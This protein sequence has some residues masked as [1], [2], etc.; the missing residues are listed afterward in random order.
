MIRVVV[1]FA[2]VLL[3][4]LACVPAAGWAQEPHFASC[5]ASAIAGN[6]IVS[7]Q[8]AGL[9]NQMRPPTPLH[10]E[11]TVTAVCLDQATT[12]PTVLDAARVTEGVTFPPKNGSRR[13]ALVV[14]EGLVLACD[15]PAEVAVGI[16]VTDVT[17]AIA[18][19]PLLP[20]APEPE[21]PLEINPLPE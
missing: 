4:A 11:A 6:L 15:P 18:C 5:N 12:P 17:H 10:L 7:G 14:N 9:G 8:I 19:T 16:R 1:V 3:A 20:P 21:P 2:L 13:Y